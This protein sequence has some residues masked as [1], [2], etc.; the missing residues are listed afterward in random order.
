VQYLALQSTQTAPG[1]WQP[2]ALVQLRLL[3]G[4]VDNYSPLSVSLCGRSRRGRDARN[5]ICRAARYVVGEETAHWHKGRVRSLGQN[6]KTSL[7]RRTTN[8]R[9]RPLEWGLRYSYLRTCSFLQESFTTLPWGWLHERQHR[10][11]DVPLVSGIS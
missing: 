11:P 10:I 3:P 9:K 7:Q 8:R 6:S 5:E 4:S 1:R 2:Y